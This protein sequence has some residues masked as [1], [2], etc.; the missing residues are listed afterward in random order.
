MSYNI[1]LSNVAEALVCE[2][3]LGSDHALSSTSSF[4]DTIPIGTISGDSEITLS[5]NTIT[6]PEGYEF[7]VRFYAGIERANVSTY[8][9][10]RLY[11]SDGSDIE[12]VITGMITGLAA[13]ESSVEET[14]AV[15]NTNNGSKS[16]IIKGYKSDSNTTSILNSLSY[17]YI[18]GFKK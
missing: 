9:Y 8:I 5:S 6:L 16:I 10:T 12:N 3:E 11:Y 1:F 7:L 4:G 13:N 15:I 17:G 14:C 2:F 18:I